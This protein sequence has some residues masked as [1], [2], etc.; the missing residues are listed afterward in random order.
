MISLEDLPIYHYL[1]PPQTTVRQPLEELARRAVEKMLDLTEAIRAG[2]S[3]AAPLNLTIPS[4]LIERDSV[5]TIAPVP[6]GE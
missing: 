1:T 2:K 3:Q 4:E 5:A 6:A